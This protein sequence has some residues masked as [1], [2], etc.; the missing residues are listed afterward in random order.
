MPGCNAAAGVGLYCTR[1]SPRD[2]LSVATREGR[3]A[4]SLRAWRLGALC[5]R[6][7]A[8]G[9]LAGGLVTALPWAWADSGMW[10][11]RR[12]PEAAGRSGARALVRQLRA[13]SKA[14]S[15]CSRSQ[16]SRYC[17]PFP[18]RFCGDLPP[19]RA[20]SPCS[21][22]SLALLPCPLAPFLLP[23]PSRLP[24]S[25]RRTEGLAH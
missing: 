14:L 17:S 15:S 22:L 2:P 9:P 23:S 5:R 11:G 4:L 20:P 13:C 8:P 10:G 24:S 3:G 25:S 12:A 1:Y 21:L 7:S 18:S 16:G 19:S 6:A